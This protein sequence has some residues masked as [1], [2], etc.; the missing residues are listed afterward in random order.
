[1]EAHRRWRRRRRRR[2]TLRQ[3]AAELRRNP[4]RPSPAKGGEARH[5]HRLL[6]LTRKRPTSHRTDGTSPRGGRYFKYRPPGRSRKSPGCRLRRT[7]RLAREPAS[8]GGARLP[9]TS[10]WRPFR[11]AAARVDRCLFQPRRQ[12]PRCMHAHH[13]H[14][15]LQIDV[16]W[17]QPSSSIEFD[18]L[19]MASCC[20]FHTRRQLSVDRLQFRRRAPRGTGAST[21]PRRT[22]VRRFDEPVWPLSLAPPYRPPSP[23]KRFLLSSEPPTHRGHRQS[24]REPLTRKTPP[25]NARAPI[26]AAHVLS[27]GR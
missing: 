2:L 24:C 8:P 4:R 18:A 6:R 11:S 25:C 5:G 27:N 22:P 26:S 16:F 1:M 19:V 7:P 15:N 20:R 3:G 12:M 21:R 10:T 13:H 14:A 23:P 17:A 9:L